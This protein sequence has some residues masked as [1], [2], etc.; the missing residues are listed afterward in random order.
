MYVLLVANTLA[1]VT[2]V[3]GTL[4]GFK[5]RSVLEA[6]EPRFTSSFI[7]MI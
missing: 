5:E 2:S 6:L 1:T 7:S 4:G 3:K